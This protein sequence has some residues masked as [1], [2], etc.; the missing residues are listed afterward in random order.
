MLF[1]RY[2]STIKRQKYTSM[3]MNGILWDIRTLLVSSSAKNRRRV[4]RKNSH[5]SPEKGLKCVIL[6]I[7]GQNLRQACQN[8]TRARVRKRLRFV[9]TIYMLNHESNR[10]S[11]REIRLLAPKN[12]QKSHFTVITPGAKIQKTVNK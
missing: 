4:L 5:F 1:F 12:C 2:S 6:V 7:I 10:F 9:C 11:G 3:G 8:D